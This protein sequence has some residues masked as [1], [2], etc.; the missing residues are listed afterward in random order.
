ME[1]LISVIRKCLTVPP[2]L[3]CPFS[4]GVADESAENGEQVKFKGNGAP[5]ERVPGIR[6]AG[7]IHT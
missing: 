1:L 5:D 6:L 3:F 7:R 4:N 2:C